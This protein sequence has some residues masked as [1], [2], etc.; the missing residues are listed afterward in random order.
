MLNLGLMDFD[1]KFWDRDEHIY[2]CRLEGGCSV[3]SEARQATLDHWNA[4]DSYKFSML[5]W[6][7]RKLIGLKNGESLI[8]SERFVDSWIEEKYVWYLWPL[9]MANITVNLNSELF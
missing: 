7:S 5:G 1:I 4:L 6:R 8:H 9:F 3:V 2:V